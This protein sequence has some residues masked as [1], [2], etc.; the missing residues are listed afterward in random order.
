MYI[1][2]IADL[3]VQINYSLSLS[4]SL[5]IY[6]LKLMFVLI[7]YLYSSIVIVLYIQLSFVTFNIWLFTIDCPIRPFYPCT[8]LYLIYGILFLLY[9]IFLAQTFQQFFHNFYKH[10]INNHIIIN[11]QIASHLY[12]GGYMPA[13]A[14][15]VLCVQSPDIII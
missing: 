14:L 6:I 9:N 1:T 3:Y 11:I 15:L 10:Y 7:C 8:I 4:L 2:T 12:S 5:F 13:R